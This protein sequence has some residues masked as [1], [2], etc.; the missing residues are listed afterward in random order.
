[1]SSLRHERTGVW[2]EQA[3]LVLL[4]VAATLAFL[5]VRQ[6]SRMQD[7]GFTAPVESATGEDLRFGEPG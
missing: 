7:A 1:L 6:V 5:L 4:I 2:F 3:G